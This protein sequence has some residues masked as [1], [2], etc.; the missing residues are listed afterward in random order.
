MPVSLVF[1]KIANAKIKGQKSKI[2]MIVT[3]VINPSGLEYIHFSAVGTL[4]NLAEL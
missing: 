3:F 4:A 2:K 1:R